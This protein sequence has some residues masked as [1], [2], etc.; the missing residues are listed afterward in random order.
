MVDPGLMTRTATVVARTTS[1]MPYIT[2]IDVYT[3]VPAFEGQF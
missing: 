3:L 1:E 2:V